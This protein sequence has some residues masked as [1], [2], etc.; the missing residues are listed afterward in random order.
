MRY[1]LLLCA[2]CLSFFLLNSVQK[3]QTPF[4]FFV[5][6]ASSGP[7]ASHDVTGQTRAHWLNAPAPVT[8]GGPSEGTG[9]HAPAITAGSG[10]S[11]VGNES[12]MTAEEAAALA[13]EMAP[14]KTA[15]PASITRTSATLYTA[16]APAIA[17][18]KAAEDLKHTTSPIA[19]KAAA[20]LKESAAASDALGTVGS[21][22][23][24]DN[25]PST[26]NQVHINP[27][28]NSTTTSTPNAGSLKTAGLA[29]AGS[30]KA[31]PQA[32]AGAGQPVVAQAGE[33]DLNAAPSSIVVAAAQNLVNAS[34]SSAVAPKTP[35]NTD[36]DDESSLGEVGVAQMT[37]PNDG[38]VANSASEYSTAYDISADF[39]VDA[40]FL[41]PTPVADAV[42]VQP[43]YAPFEM[44]AASYAYA[45]WLRD[46]IENSLMD[47]HG[48][49][50]GGI[51]GLNWA[52]ASVNTSGS[53]RVGGSTLTG[54]T[55]GAFADMPLTKSLHFRPSF[56]YSDEGFQPNVQGDKVN[57]HVAF[58][59][60]PLDLVYHTKL[61]GKRFFVG[62]G[63]YLAYALNGTYTLKG[64][65][66][67]MTFGNNYNGGDDLRRLDMGANVMAGLLMDRNF[68]IGAKFDW[69]LSNFAPSGSGADIHTRS[70][71]ISIGYVFRNRA[72]SKT[73]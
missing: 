60:A 38:P 5:S 36:G 58:L 16:A 46:S 42:M 28:S 6:K 9:L 48:I 54:F 65:N 24:I 26:T 59:S 51:A 7:V 67:D 11:A 41:S 10:S 62:A 73:N 69:G 64:I 52:G 50:F 31:G 44:S 40:D 13:G 22:E 66:T 72:N 4:S 61:A 33:A 19:N 71:G 29:N 37:S 15:E 2:L 39:S 21:S 34:K 49:Q 12:T 20:T 45:K 14:A 3:Y 70:F 27:N 68:I 53:G 47:A 43:N 55:L 8:K 17:S 57:I 56:L 35:V 30:P 23:I 1:V 32:N 25:Q 18:L 63:P